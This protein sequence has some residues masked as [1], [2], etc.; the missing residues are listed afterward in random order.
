MTDRNANLA[1]L[2]TIKGS[3][4][5]LKVF[6]EQH[7]LKTVKHYDKNCQLNKEKK[8]IRKRKAKLT[9]KFF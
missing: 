1:C 7:Y 9:Q 3:G 5:L 8:E 2:L 6:L 4:S